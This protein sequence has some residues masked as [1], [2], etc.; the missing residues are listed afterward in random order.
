MNS[1][2]EDFIKVKPVWESELKMLRTLLLKE[3]F[4]ETIKWGIPVYT[5]KGKNVVGMAAFKSYVGLWFYQ[6]VFLKDKDE[7]LVNAQKGKTKAMRQWR[8][9][10]LEEIKANRKII[11][12]Y[13]KEAIQNQKNGKELKPEKKAL[14][15][16]EELKEVLKAD[17][18]LKTAFDDLK[19]GIKKEYAEYIESAKRTATKIS[20]LEKIEPL[21]LQ[22]ISLNDKY[23]K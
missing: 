18:K 8:F 13:L 20:R 12:Q 17:Q 15:I 21:I 19:P 1:K 7:K 4:E 11:S 2:V 23:R 3:N 6:G 9:S 16:P 5:V 14:V 10:S 22:G